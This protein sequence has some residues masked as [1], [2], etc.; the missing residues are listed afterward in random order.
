MST[1]MKVL[2]GALLVALSTSANATAIVIDSAGDTGN[3]VGTVGGTARVFGVNGGLV[4][5]IGSSKVFLTVQNNG[6]EQG[7]N[8]TGAVQ[9][10]TTA[11][12]TTSLLLSEIPQ[13]TIQGINYR[14][15]AFEANQQGGDSLLSLNQIQIFQAA[16]GNLTGY[17]AGGPNIG[18]ATSLVFDWASGT[19]TL[20][21]DDFVSGAS[22][23]EM[24]MFVP[25]SS[26]SASPFVYLYVN[27]GAPNDSNAGPDRWLVVPPGGGCPPGVDCVPTLLTP[28]VPEPASLALLGLALAGAGWSRRRKRK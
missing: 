13:V 19:D 4:Q 6:T 3:L 17:N 10:D 9:F 25:A 18:G 20:T 2:G 28:G 11:S 1:R 24:L 22:S 7:Y 27:A 21:V 5:G 14:G 8:T 23:V 16:A 12:G 15:F 26:F